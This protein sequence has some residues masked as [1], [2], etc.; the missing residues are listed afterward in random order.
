MAGTS[1]I[2]FVFAATLLLC[3]VSQTRCSSLQEKRFVSALNATA[4]FTTFSVPL[5]NHNNTWHR[6]ADRVADLTTRPPHLRKL[7]SKAVPAIPKSPRDTTRDSTAERSTSARSLSAG[8][9]RQ[10][11]PSKANHVHTPTTPSTT[12]KSG[13]SG[14]STPASPGGASG[15]SSAAQRQLTSTVEGQVYTISSR[16]E[17]LP[18]TSLSRYDLR[19]RCGSAQRYEVNCR[20][21]RRL[22]DIKFAAAGREFNLR[23]KEYVVEVETSTGNRCYSGFAEASQK[24]GVTWHLG[25]PFLRNVYTVLV[26]PTSESDGLGR[27]GFAYSR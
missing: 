4:R 10:Q 2:R 9:H 11:T 12:P 27:V 16:K 25:H 7:E 1:R 21:V 8:T 17:E 20:N 3:A 24:A 19:K 14:A 26:A 18:S 22:P 5:K 13:A 6:V 23:P 15:H